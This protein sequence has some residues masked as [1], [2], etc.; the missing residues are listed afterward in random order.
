[1]TRNAVFFG[2]LVAATSTGCGDPLVAP[3]LIVNNRVLGARVEAAT[4][5]GRAWLAPS[6]AAKVRWLLASPEGAPTM[7]WAFSLC[8]AEPVTRG[9]PICMAPSFAQFVSPAAS[10]EEPYFDFVMPDVSN[11]E[12]GEQVAVSGAFCES[13]LPESTSPGGTMDLGAT[14]T[15]CPDRHEQPLF[16]SLTIPTVVDDQSNANPSFTPIAIDFDGTAWPDWTNAEATAEDCAGANLSWPKVAANGARHELQLR[17]P[18]GMSEP[19]PVVS[20]HSSSRE[21]LTVSHFVTGGD[22]ERAYSSVDGSSSAATI[23]VAW[24][25]PNSITAA[26]VVR[27]YFVIRDGRGG[28]DW[29]RRSLCVLP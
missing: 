21:T 24:N 17:I 13:G 8:R 4:D 10:A 29:T 20:T 11:F 15:R 16:V 19:L 25:A 3:E 1:M 2:L 28:A 23:R 18:E 9:L 6:E 14:D 26:Q 22:L 7:N 5:P 12:H 27:F